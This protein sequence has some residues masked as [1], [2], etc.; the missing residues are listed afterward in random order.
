MDNDSYITGKPTWQPNCHKK[1]AITDIHKDDV[2]KA[3]SKFYEPSQLYFTRMI[4]KESILARQREI[5][6]SRSLFS[7][8]LSLVVGIIVWEAED[9]CMPLVI[10]LSVVVTMSLLSALQ[11]LT[12]VEHKP[13]SES[14]A[15]LSINWFILGTLAYP[16]LPRIASFL[17]PLALSFL[18]RTL[19]WLVG[20]LVA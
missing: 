7:V 18:Q 17:A 9:P 5:A 1:Q 20:C 3:G 13:A 8:L 6:L 10:A 11:L 12:R 16:M 14:V 15:L 19:K 4:S 2:L